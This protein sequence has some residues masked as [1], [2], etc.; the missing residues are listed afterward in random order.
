VFLGANLAS[1]ALKQQLVV[2]HSSTKTEYRAVSVAEASWLCQLH[3][4]LYDPLMR[5]T[6]VYCDNVSVVYL[7]TSPVHHQGT[8]HVEIDLHFVRERVA[9]AFSASRPPCISWTS[10]PR[11]CRRVY[12]LS[13][14]SVS[15]SI[16]DRIDTAG[17]LDSYLGYVSIL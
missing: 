12:S 17:V 3:H 14:A 4:E 9:V 13:F 11:D 10:S 6:I 15:T 5:S 1:W 8:K 2:S 7:F 16:Q